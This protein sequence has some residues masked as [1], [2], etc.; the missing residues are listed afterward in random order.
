V[1]VSHAV[2]WSMNEYAAIIQPCM[3]A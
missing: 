3:L 1:A 2:A